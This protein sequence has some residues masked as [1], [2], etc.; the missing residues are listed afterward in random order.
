[1]TKT[2]NSG[3]SGE[4]IRFAGFLKSRG[5]K[6]F[7][8][9][10]QDAVRSLRV[11]SIENRDDFF[12]ALRATLS[13]SDLEWEQFRSLF[14]EFWQ[15][16]VEE[17]TKTDFQ[18]P[19]TDEVNGEDA[20]DQDIPYEL[21]GEKTESKKNEGEKEWLEGVAYSC[22]SRVEQSDLGKF[23]K[24][25]IQVAQLLLK[26]MMEP[27]RL[28]LMRRARRSRKK[29]EPGFSPDDQEE[30][31]DRRDAPETPFQ[32][33]KEASQA[34]CYFGGCERVHGSVRS[35]CDAFSSWASRN[36]VEG[37]GLRFF[38]FPDPHYIPDQAS[39]R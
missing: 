13:S 8:T 33:K 25:D 17:D 7:Q 38:H 1:M 16:V 39:E 37:R 28:N 31:Q 21:K 34:A 15:K 23:E 30:P 27:F 11:V 9:G 12:F 24:A 10:I 18:Q 29:G 22:L 35:I 6:V 19:G 32:G 14:D 26:N 2:E 5:F 36:R 20:Q 3:L 4:I